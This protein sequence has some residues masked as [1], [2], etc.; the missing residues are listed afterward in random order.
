MR[1]GSLRASSGSPQLRQDAAAGYL[2]EMAASELSLSRAIGRGAVASIAGTATMTAFQ[3]LI[4]IPLTGRGDS[5]APAK[6]AERVLPVRAKSRKGR[7]QLN[8]AA[9]F[10]IGFLWG[11]AYGVA[12]HAGLRGQKAVA[13]V[14]P[15]VYSGD[16]LLNTVLGVYAPTK[17]TKQDVV[18]DVGE[19]FIQA[20]ATGLFFDRFLDPERKR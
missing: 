6:F 4:E 2:N 12:A 11:A 19:K 17:W 3:K 15:A 5:Y 13:A 8:Y 18:I 10:G 1:S 14:F 9:H 20:G 7:K 16:V